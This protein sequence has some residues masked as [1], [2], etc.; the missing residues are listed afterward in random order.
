[1]DGMKLISTKLIAP[2]PRKNYIRREELF[3]KLQ[4]M[5]EYKVILLQGAAG[6]GKTTLLA[7]YMQESGCADFRWI[8]LDED[9]NDVF[10]FWYYV[11]EA[12]KGDLGRKVDDL[13][14]IFEA[15]PQKREMENMLILIVNQLHDIGGLTI[16]LDDFH[17]VE[18]PQLL[19]TIEF[20]IKY[21]PDH[22][23]LVLLTRETPKLYLGELMISGK[24]LEIDESDLKFSADEAARF[25]QN[26]L[27]A[28][29]DDATAGKL[30]ELAEGWV[31]GLQLMALA[32]SHK[33]DMA[34]GS[35]KGL[36]KY[37]TNYLSNEILRSLSEEETQ[38]LIRT[39]ILSY[40]NESI[41]NQLLDIDV[42]DAR[43]LIQGFIE[44]N[45]FLVTIDEKAGLYRYHNLPVRCC[46]ASEINTPKRSNA[47][48]K[49]LRWR[50]DSSTRI[51]ATSL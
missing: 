46:W 35:A 42:D 18:D 4:R 41:C 40:F 2:A 33:N 44:K 32:H 20:F 50:A 15:L 49:R 37:M 14:S 28:E 3:R 6:S 1:M 23:R 19:Q 16:V 48:I 24:Y 43:T 29:M 34:F 31:G 36:N 27:A 26:T 47:S 45:M 17:T 39:S 9:N 12:L 51:F 11:L 30:N 13:L 21:S 25:L 10:S 5:Q 22:I 38:F 8:A 7:S